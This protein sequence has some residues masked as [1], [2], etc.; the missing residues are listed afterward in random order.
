MESLL[1]TA[2]RSFVS[3]MHIRNLMR[4]EWVSLFDESGKELPGIRGR[5]GVSALTAGHTEVGV[6]LIEMSPGSSFPLHT[7]DGDHILYIH[8]GTGSVHINGTDHPVGPGD[9]VFIPA[10][11]PHG[12]RASHNSTEPLV[13]LA[14]GHPHKH[15][16]ATDRMHLVH[17]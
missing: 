8:S 12:V 11:Y 7:H 15:L 13:F 5:I 3:E 9:S 2:A 4:G 1:R 10:E 17:E 14:F 6:D 16:S